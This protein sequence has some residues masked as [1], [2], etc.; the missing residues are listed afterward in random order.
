MCGRYSMTH[1]ATELAER[2]GIEPPPMLAPRYNI[3]PTQPVLIVREDRHRNRL[4]ESTHVVWG[5]IPPWADDTKIAFRMINARADAV[6]EKPA[7]R[8]AFRRRRCLVP[9][10]GFYEWKKTPLPAASQPDDL[11]AGEDLTQAPEGLGA[12]QKFNREP[13][14]I[15][16]ISGELFAFAG[17]W[18]VWDGPNGET[19]ESCTILTTD[20]NS[21]LAP[22]H[23]RMPVILPPNQFSE[24][25]DTSNEDVA[26]LSHLLRPYPADAMEAYVVSSI[27]NSPRNDEPA[28]SA[29]VERP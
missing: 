23:D 27:V 19:I 10:S 9:A 1:T 16:M 11:F 17:L 8:H 5:L 29:P 7:F 2:F 20:A 28:C 3:A 26:T 21:L 4:R 6:A 22:I 25:L 12:A 13:N 15:H 14:F 18:E 24:W